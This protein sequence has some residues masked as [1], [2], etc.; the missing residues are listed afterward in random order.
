MEYRQLPHGMER[1]R[2]T[3]LGLGMGDIQH[4]PA[5]KSKRSFAK[6]LTMASIFS[7]SVPAVRYMP[8]LVAPSKDSGKR[9]CCRCTSV[10]CVTSRGN[11]TD[12][13]ILIPSKR[14][15]CGNWKCL[16]PTMWI[17]D[18]CIVWMKTWILTNSLGME[19]KGYRPSHRLLLPYAFGCKSHSEYRPD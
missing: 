11:T 17:L 1:K 8:H 9:C 6:Q 13:G 4:T 19:G 18:S 10:R 12:A 7:T 2:F 3:V 5:R 15:S 14:P 16:V